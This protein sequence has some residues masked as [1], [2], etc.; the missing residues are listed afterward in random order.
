MAGNKFDVKDIVY[1]PVDGGTVELVDILSD[2]GKSITK[3]IVPVANVGYLYKGLKLEEEKEELI[4]TL[5]FKSTSS[6]TKN[7]RNGNTKWRAYI[8]DQMNI[9]ARPKAFLEILNFDVSNDLLT[10]SNSTFEC[11]ALPSNV[12]KG[13]IL[14]LLNPYG[15]PRYYGV[16]SS[17]EE[18]T[19]QTCQ[20]QNL[21]AG[22][23]VYDLPNFLGTGDNKQWKIKIYDTPIGDDGTYSY[24]YPTD[25]ESL[26]AK[27]TYNK[28]DSEI[29]MKMNLG[30]IYTCYAT[31][32]V[33]SEKRVKVD[34][35]FCADDIGT[36]TI[37]GSKVSTCKYS[38]TIED[39]IQTESCIFRQGWNKVEVVYSDLLPNDN[40]WRFEIFDSLGTE[41]CLVDTDLNNL[42]AKESYVLSD[43]N[44]KLNM[45][46]GDAYTARAKT[47][48]YCKEAKTVTFA[49]AASYRGTLIVNDVAI[50]DYI[51]YEHTSDNNK[52]GGEPSGVVCN[53]KAGWNTVE[54][55]YSGITTEE[56]KYQKD[57][58]TLTANDLKI[59]KCGEFDN[60][61]SYISSDDGFSLTYNNQN[62]SECGLFT[63]LTSDSTNEVTSLEQTFADKFKE[64]IAGKIRD[65]S[66]VDPLVKQRLGCFD[67]SVCSNTNG[68]FLSQD[69][70][71]TIDME[72]M[73]Y[74][75][76]NQYQIMVDVKIP[77]EGTPSV[78]IGKSQ[79]GEYLKVADNNNTIVDI[80]PVTEIEETNRL[81]IYDSD[82]IYRTSYATKS[83]GTRVKEPSEISSRFGVVNTQIVYSD[84][85]IEDLLAANLPEEIYNHK[86]TFTLRLIDKL[87]YYDDF[88]LGMPIKVWK[89]I[90]YYRT[91]L[92]GREFSK[93]T[94]KPVTLINYTC[95]N[96]R[97]SLTKKLSLKFGVIR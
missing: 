93:E 6:A 26:T 9:A 76:Y 14:T 5:T 12:A 36:L 10:T 91:V 49:F 40:G 67:V 84:D 38:G 73:I 27:N 43:S 82:G 18:T 41:R 54:V 35:S 8:K 3:K 28:N 24:L 50:Y 86:L 69:D 61:T 83:D 29:G 55:I 71:Y 44:T 80:S 57:G 42:A 66:Y 4:A 33:Y 58:F 68:S 79:I 46:L 1:N 60:V 92:T 25:L 88:T 96:V 51:Y 77:Y 87:Y 22:T 64:Y 72:Q 13:D 62:F 11:M 53:L 65:S 21:F 7:L 39:S 16:I 89:D 95:G 23:W 75:L 32:Y 63:K 47:N 19:I 59:S 70:N 56:S 81:I 2:D 48:I 37:N 97:T 74:D 52:N 78:I 20:I 30:D 90:E 94:N 34:I 31:C 17:I 45:D 15:K 85:P